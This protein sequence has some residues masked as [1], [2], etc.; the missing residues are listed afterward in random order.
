MKLIK[1]GAE[2]KL[3]LSDID[4]RK[5][6]VK[7]RIKKSYRIKQ[8]DEKLRKQRTSR[9]SNL[10]SEARRVGVLTPRIVKVEKN[11]IIMDYID[12]Q[13]I[14]ELLNSSNKKT[15]VKLSFEIGKIIGKLHSADIIHGDLTTSNMIFKDGNIFFID[16]GL[17]Q[18]SRKIENK[19]TDLKL[20]LE[21][22]RSTH[23]SI[24]EE[25]WK[26]ILKGYRKE[27]KGADKVLKKVGE[28]AK[29]ARY[30]K[31]RK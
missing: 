23:F 3:Y 15:V 16:F 1:Q 7:D 18:F 29:R 11:K 22:L 31:E 25:C 9:E 10:L 14:K 20:L 4:G 28:I 26:Q 24:A 21:A 13:R 12:G 19:G 5:V 6:L 17:G 8:I 30:V 27:Y 2:A